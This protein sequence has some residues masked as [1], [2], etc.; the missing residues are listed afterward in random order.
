M[1]I[2]MDYRKLA[3]AALQGLGETHQ[4]LAKSALPSTLLDLV[5]LRVSEI[6]GC[7]YC[8]S[9]HGRDLLRAGVALDKLVLLSAWRETGGLYSDTERAALQ[10]AESLTDV[11][12]TGAP[13]QDYEALVA[14][15]NDADA[16]QLTVA[17]ALINAYN[18]IAIGF[19]QPPVP[20]PK[21]PSV[22]PP[23][24]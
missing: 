24:D 11:S 6:N 1:T 8:L 18:R 2:R 5:Y 4:Q 10:W 22:L 15:F 21:G 16:A 3:A 20:L 14:N 12:R 9:S 19:R 17:I 23:D 13:D 7:A